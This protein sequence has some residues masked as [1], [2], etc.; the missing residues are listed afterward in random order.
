MKKAE[1]TLVFCTRPQ[2]WSQ[3][4][5]GSIRGEILAYH[6]TLTHKILAQP[7]DDD[8]AFGCDI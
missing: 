5:R 6:P 1:Q 4:I 7:S 3:R 2:A 8:A